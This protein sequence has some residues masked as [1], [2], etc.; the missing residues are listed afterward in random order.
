[1]S[2]SEQ[3][4]ANSI[5]NSMYECGQR[6]AEEEK[7]RQLKNIWNAAIEAAALIVQPNPHV[8]EERECED[9]ARQIRGLKK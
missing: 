6:L 7:Q 8:E 3:E 2:N 1:M 5:Y 4:Y 9:I